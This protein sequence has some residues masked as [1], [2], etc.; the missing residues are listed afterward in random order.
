MTERAL[1]SIRAFLGL[2][3]IAVLAACS[4]HA[5]LPRAVAPFTPTPDADFRRG[6]PEALTDREPYRVPNLHTFELANGFKCMV[7]E[8]FDLPIVSLTL[9][10]RAGTES[11]PEDQA[12]IA[13]LV[14]SLLNEGTRL[15]D[16]SSLRALSVEGVVPGVRTSANGTFVVMNTLAAHLAPSLEAVAR[17]IQHPVFDSGA[18]AVARVAQ[19][20][21][22][23]R[24]S[25]TAEFHLDHAVLS[26][27]RGADHYLSRSVLGRSGALQSLA[28]E[29]VRRFYREHYGPRDSVLVVVG[30]AKAA[31]VAPLVER[32]FGPWAAAP[33]YRGS[34]SALPAPLVPP[35]HPLHAFLGETQ[36]AYLAFGLAGRGGL[37]PDYPALRLGATLIGR[38]MSS[39]LNEKLRQHQAAS[40]GVGASYVTRADSGE[41]LIHADTRPEEVR[42]TLDLLG[43]ELGRLA[44][45]S[46]TASEVET[47]RASLRAE[48]QEGFSTNIAHAAMLADLHVAFLPGNFH[49]AL[50]AK[51]ESVRV[52]D[53]RAAFA[54][55]LSME[56]AAIAVYGH[57][58][59]LKPQLL[60]YR[61]NWFSLGEDE[62]E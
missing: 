23:F 9:A 15:D 41:L 18:V 20:E 43:Q 27:L 16:G 52:E 4:G 6:P 38:L 17:I 57:P 60:G 5:R 10:N 13:A 42:A 1:S 48:L 28:A 47:A 61:V 29:H 21:A 55:Q 34:L 12:G 14:G 36:Q 22:L 30:A 53:V 46:L 56:G 58:A 24:Q 49:E 54:R 59:D 26:E 19:M 8:R 37:D 33:D 25:T 7:V 45:S 50:L 3:L 35:P 2:A 39:K 32:L 11:E 62:N 40:Y 44:T 51:L 31:T